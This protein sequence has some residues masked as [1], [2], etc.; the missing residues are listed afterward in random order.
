M[1]LQPNDDGSALLIV[2]LKFDEG[3]SFAEFAVK[4]KSYES[5]FTCWWTPRFERFGYPKSV[6]E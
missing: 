2:Y 6:G 5:E 1:W 4:L 3:V